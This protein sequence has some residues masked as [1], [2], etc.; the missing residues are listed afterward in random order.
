MKRTK[1][2]CAAFLACMGGFLFLPGAP[3]VDKLLIVR[4]APPHGIALVEVRLPG[5]PG[6][7]DV[8]AQTLDG[9]AEVPAQIVRGAGDDPEVAVLALR[10]PR[11][12]EHRL[13]LSLSPRPA[14]EARFPE[15][16]VRTPWAAFTHDRGEMGGL[17]SR[18]EFPRT[19]KVFE[20]FSWNDRLHHREKGGFLL[21]NDR[22]PA[23]ELVSRG[24]VCSVVRVRARY[25]RGDEPPPSRPEAAYDW[26]YFHDLPLVLV[27]AEIRQIAPFAWDEIHFLELNFP[28][29]SFSRW[30]GGDPP[31]EGAFAAEKKSFSFPSWG[32]VLDGSNAVAVVRGGRV[33]FYDGR[34]EYGTYLHAHGDAAWQGWKDLR[35]RVSA[36]LWVGSDDAPVAASAAASRALPDGARAVLTTPEA[37]AR[38]DAAWR[39]GDCRQRWRAAAAERLEAQGRFGEI[40]PWL[41]GKSPG[42]WTVLDASDLALILERSSGGLAVRSLYDMKAGR[43]LL[44]A[45]A[46][47]LFTL[48]L[49]HAP[50]GRE[51]KLDSSSG[52][53]LV[54]IRPDGGPAAWTLRWS[55]PA[56]HEGVRVTVG[57][58]E[59]PAGHSVS[60]TFRVE[61]VGGEWGVWRAAFPRLAVDAFGSDVAVFF[62]RGPGEVQ[63]GLAGRAFRYAG[64]YP[65]GWTGMPFMAAYDEKAE[66]GL[67][68][69]VHDGE[70]H[71]KDILLE[72]RPEGRDFLF[73]FDHPAPDMGKAGVG[74]ALG[75]R[76]V[77]R[78]LRGDWFDAARMY[79]DWVRR[80]A[81]WFPRPGADGR[82]D[83][84]A[85]MRELPAWA[86]GGGA[87]GSCVAPVKGFRE[88]LGMPAGFH[89]YNWHRIPFDNDY[90][91]YFPAKDGFAEGV[92][93][94][95]A[96]GVFVMP[97]INGRLWDT[98]DRGGEDGEFS[99]VALPA[100]TKDEKGRVL[101]ETYGSKEP[102][103]SPV[104]LAA[105]CP[106]T[107]FWQ[108]RVRGIV[109]RLMRECG[110]KAVYIDQVAAAK[111]RL[112]FDASHGHPLGGG[113]WW[114]RGYGRMLERLRE[115][116]PEGCVITTECNAEPYVR[117]FDGYLTWHWQHDG[118]VPA[119][120]AVYGGAVQMFGRAYRGGP[121]KSLALRMKAGQQLV[122]G[123]QIGWIDP[124]VAKDEESRDFFRDIV[125]LRWEL[126]RYFHA[127]EMARPPRLE[128]DV[129][130]VRAD[131]QWRGT[132]P[133][134]TDAVLSGAWRL[135]GEKK[136]V[137][138]FVNVSDRPVTA[139][140][141][142]DP[143]LVNG[144]ARITA[145]PGG[146]A[147]LDRPVEFAARRAWAWEVSG[148]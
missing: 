61:G 17:P 111:P 50:S 99:R 32:A 8:S 105:M 141:K 106:A 3:S 95:Q 146:E 138:I 57:A 55:R 37:R 54:E 22:E 145:I 104:T 118:Q 78:L 112:C 102:D 47:P 10:L 89:W 71:T 139:A 85:W 91:H 29:A 46:E 58:V 120:P 125:K 30:A 69:A 21:K 7:L 86:L 77:W 115:E 136:A 19:G 5:L 26:F 113:N 100:A 124:G 79:R 38:I 12:G 27:R 1:R 122:F 35:R 140:V 129:P 68:V 119:F 43:E 110:T 75:G 65:D 107:E 81:Q 142:P 135:P 25:R 53:D 36:W 67:Y 23:V 33:L 64:T 49:R 90:P 143:V 93:E 34:G 45:C 98:R 101:T 63:R 116:M 42:S 80:E 84:P 52:W 83:T 41:E 82:A 123:E 28:D 13:K 134:T 73:A 109:L 114:W 18:I 130:P 66:T 94:L 16:P 92:K 137:L 72:S 9:G 44:S 56:G 59:D 97:Y 108:D 14:A 126:R 128:G 121:E 70:A 60:W 74:F 15:G 62:P 76:A 51:A 88:Y 87:P 39:D 132:W 148:R 11:G 96:A 4:D 147:A 133:V 117:W 20:G 40:A 144:A 48:T 24:P 103:G 31:S 2:P 127:G 6:P 131:W